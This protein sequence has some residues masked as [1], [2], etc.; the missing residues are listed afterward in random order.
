MQVVDLVEAPQMGCQL[1]ILLKDLRAIHWKSY[2]VYI[3]ELINDP[4]MVGQM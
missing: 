1:G 3:V 4:P 2:L